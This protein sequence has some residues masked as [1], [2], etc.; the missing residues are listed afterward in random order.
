MSPS[1]GALISILAVRSAFVLPLPGT[2]KT[3]ADPPCERQTGGCTGG[4]T[5]THIYWTPY[6]N[7]CYNTT[8]TKCCFARIFSVDCSDESVGSICL[9]QWFPDPYA[10]CT[11]D[12]QASDTCED[13]H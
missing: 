2:A 3:A 11:G 12:C 8:Q 5:I 10:Q 9:G 7:T 1:T 4:A 13:S 6:Q